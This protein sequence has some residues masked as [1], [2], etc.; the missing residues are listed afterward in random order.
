MRKLR[1]QA[2]FCR[3][4]Q[5]SQLTIAAIPDNGLSSFLWRIS[6]SFFI[7][8]AYLQ[9]GWWKWWK[10][11][12]DPIGDLKD[13]VTSGKELGTLSPSNQPT[14]G[15]CFF[16]MPRL[17]E[18]QR[19]PRS[20]RT[21]G[22]PLERPPKDSDLFP[23]ILCWIVSSFS[24]PESPLILLRGDHP[25]SALP[26]KT[27]KKHNHASLILLFLWGYINRNLQVWK[28]NSPAISFCTLRNLG[29]PLLSVFFLHPIIHLWARRAIYLTFPLAASSQAPGKS[30]DS[31]KFKWV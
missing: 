27:D 25:L 17:E 21:D 23:P 31:S 20:W 7:E 5:Q 28:H 14:P 2:H 3:K 12:D 11:T 13:C 29:G 18:S 6:S 30:G 10:G 4:T 16:L 1:K 22:E 26:Y 15:C 8:P 9:T 24:S 19:Q